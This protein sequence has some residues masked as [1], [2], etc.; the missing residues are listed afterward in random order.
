MKIP[1]SFFIKA[2]MYLVLLRSP[3][4]LL[5]ISAYV[6]SD[7]K[8]FVS[9][10][11]KLLPFIVFMLLSVIYSTAMGNE[12]GNILG[13]TRDIF[14]AIIVAALL[15]TACKFKDN[16]NICYQ[17][18]KKC[19]VIISLAKLMILAY[20]LISGAGVVSLVKQISD[21]WGIEMMTMGVD[22]SFLGRIQIPMD[23]ATPFF[24]YFYTK[25]LLN[26]EK[27]FSWA[28][29]AYFMLLISMLL[30]FSRLMWGQTAIF[31]MLAVYIESSTS[32]ILK[33]TLVGSI[34]SA[35]VLFFTPIGDAVLSIVEARVSGQEINDSSDMERM[36][37]NRMLLN[38]V[39]NHPIIGHGLGYYIPNL[40]RSSSMRYLY[41]TQSL[42]MVM[43]MG[44]LGALIFLML[45]FWL[46]LPREKNISK[47]IGPLFFLFF[48]VI[49][50][51]FNPFLFGASGGVILYLSSQ[52][53]SIRCL[54]S[55]KLTYNR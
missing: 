33:L 28:S 17:T 36:L 12:I 11:Y 54:V 15:I 43:T 38:E 27:F 45:I 31:I 10:V 4:I 9:F 47:F 6:F 14:L 32:R 55:N 37:Q 21:A 2:S 40:T 46:V 19:F 18:I 3:I 23:S 29:I 39:Y 51:S 34:L 44:V 22:N 7:R 49:C 42:S 50:G 26:K 25:E 20:A 24:L 52:F 16:A 53:N 13:Q 8:V 5:T 48:W 1:K 41:E 30:T 35:L